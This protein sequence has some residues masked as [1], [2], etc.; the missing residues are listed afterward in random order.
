MECGEGL[1]GKDSGQSFTKGA[2]VHGSHTLTDTN[3]WHS[4][5]ADKL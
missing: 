1:P 5:I 3:E 4:G 2:W